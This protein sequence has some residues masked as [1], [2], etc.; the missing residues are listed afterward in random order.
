VPSLRLEPL[1][2]V[3]LLPGAALLPASATHSEAPRPRTE[4]LPEV[5]DLQ[6]T[7]GTGRANSDRLE[8]DASPAVAGLPEV[9]VLGSNQ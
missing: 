3:E 8:K 7:S 4:V 1:R 2:V 6:F 5:L 9:A